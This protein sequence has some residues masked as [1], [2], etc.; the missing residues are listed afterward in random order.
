MNIGIIKQAF[1]L[2][3]NPF[4]WEKALSAALCGGFPVLIGL[5][6]NQVRYG[7]LGAIGGFTYLYVFN[8]PYA[9]RVKKIF[10]IAIGITTSVCLG[11]FVA[12]Y[13]ALIVLI[14]GLIGIITTFI[15]GILKITGPAAVFFI[16]SFTM[17]TGIKLENSD[18]P[19]FIGV[20]FASS[21]FSWIVSLI[22]YFFNPHGPELKKIKVVYL[23]LTEFAEVI[24]SKD[25]SQVR[26][27]VVN[28]LREAEEILNV[29]Y[30]SWKV[31]F[32]FNRL[33]LLNKHANKLF[34]TL[35]ELNSKS[36][37][38]LPK[39]LIEMIRKLQ[40]GVDLS[41]DETIRINKISREFHTEYNKVLE[42]IYDIESIMNLPLRYIGH[43]IEIKKPSITIKFIKAINKDSIVFVNSIRYGIVLSVSAIVAFYFPFTRPYWITL[44]CAAVMCGSTIMATFHRAIQRSVGTIIGIVLAIAILSFQPQGFMVVVVN[45]CLTALIELAISRNY[46]L[47]AIFITPN[48]ILIAENST[49]IH[50]IG[51]FATARITDIIV[52]SAIGLIGTYIIGR[53][54]ASSRLP[55]LMA[56][57]LRSHS[58][59]LVFLASNN[60]D[61]DTNAI[62]E[63]MEIDH[64]NFKMAYNTALGEIPNNEEML[65]MM[66]PAFYSL[67]HISYLLTQY[68]SEKGHISIKDDELA[69]LILIYETM[70]NN[71]EQRNSIKLRTVEI[72]KEISELCEEI[73]N[74]QS[75]L[76]IKN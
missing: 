38:E 69:K 44:S 49:Q 51:Y 22:G 3:K 32:I 59:V 15:F 55:D 7:L 40:A 52:G 31:S 21:M 50:N 1:K 66:W 54:S 65:E 17:T 8:E 48:S 25:I 29:G 5:L 62:R 72:I 18:I 43:S 60:S 56:K 4:P 76:S 28:S 35:L 64:M 47:A 34:L 42:V 73:N 27:R 45:M 6:L 57:L 9:Q 46:A 63:K 74:L 26:N 58:R 24:G 70:A 41:Q 67:E 16:L 39:E 68:C 75:A 61:N 71:M 30:N 11:I 20:V 19:I 12:P 33:V 23:A 14:V 53:K 37:N 2:N 13:P 36:S 10:F